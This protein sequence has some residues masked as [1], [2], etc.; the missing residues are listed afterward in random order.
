MSSALDTKLAKAEALGFKVR[1]RNDNYAVIQRG[2]KQYN[3]LGNKFNYTLDGDYVIG[4]WEIGNLLI[5]NISNKDI[6]EYGGDTKQLVFSLN[7]I[8][9]FGHGERSLDITVTQASDYG[10]MIN[11]DLMAP[12]GVIHNRYAANTFGKVCTVDE[13]IDDDYLNKISSRDVVLLKI[14]TFGHLF[15]FHDELN[16]YE[17]Y[18]CSSLGKALCITD[19]IKEPENGSINMVYKRNPDIFRVYMYEYRNICGINRATKIVNIVS[20]DVNL[21]IKD[22]VAP[23][24]E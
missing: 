5:V 7:G 24:V 23:L 13:V 11:F 3:I 12:K 9:V 2:E 10:N 4:E 20:V 19:C 1:F 8:I 6:R 18:L 16:K 22:N 14:M 15:H 21:D 17:Y